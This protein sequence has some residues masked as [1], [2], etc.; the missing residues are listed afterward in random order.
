MSE[1]RTRQKEE[2]IRLGILVT[3][4]ADLKKWSNMDSTCVTFETVQRVFPAMNFN[5]P[6]PIVL[7]GLNNSDKG[8]IWEESELFGHQKLEPFEKLSNSDKSK[9]EDKLRQSGLTS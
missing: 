4:T 8:E 9:W 6:T 2:M 3:A 1:S 7:V 5:I